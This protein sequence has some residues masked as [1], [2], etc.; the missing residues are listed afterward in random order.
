MLQE[1]FEPGEALE[2]LE[3]ERVTSI[4]SRAHLDHRMLSHPDFEAR[5]LSSVRRIYKG[6]PLAMRLGFQQS[7][8]LEGY[9]MTETMTLVSCTPEDNSAVNPEWPSSPRDE[10]PHCRPRHGI[11]DTRN[12]PGRICVRG[13][14]LM[15]CYY[16]RPLGEY[17]DA[18]GYFLTSD[19]GVLDDDGRLHWTGRLDN[20]A[21]GP[22]PT[23]TR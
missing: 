5:D 6:S 23:S 8:E 10:C 2:L 20:M 15:R 9:G 13:A 12:A 22:A 18:D 3:S 4:L 14:T 21:K 16:N 17:F 11:R 7:T 1:H 19:A